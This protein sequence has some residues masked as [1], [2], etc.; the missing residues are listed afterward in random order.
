MNARYIIRDVGQKRAVGRC[1]TKYSLCF[2]ITSMRKAM[3][4]LLREGDI[5]NASAATAHLRQHYDSRDCRVSCIGRLIV[6]SLPRIERKQHRE[7]MFRSL[8]FEWRVVARQL[9]VSRGMR[10]LAHSP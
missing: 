3:R 9:I 2:L 5:V 7:K 10:I 1:V 8:A 4:R 6:H